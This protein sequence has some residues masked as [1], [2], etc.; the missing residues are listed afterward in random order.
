MRRLP[1]TITDIH[2]LLQDAQQLPLAMTHYPSRG[3]SMAQE[4]YQ[5]KQGKLFLK[6][7][8]ERNHQDCQVNPSSGTLAEREF[9]SCRLA[10][11][12][13]LEVPDLRLLDAMTTVQIW[14]DIPDAHSYSTLQGPIPYQEQMT[15]I[16]ECGVFDWITGQIDR[17]DANY[18]YDF[19]RKR[20]IL[21]DAAHAFLRFDG[22]IPDY[23][24]IFEVVSP[25][26]LQRRMTT[27][28][29]ESLKG[30]KKAALRRLVPLRETREQEALLRRCDQVR[31]I[32]TINELIQLYR[33]GS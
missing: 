7:V 11:H 1:K 13:G 14:Y 15:H 2:T 4:L 33:K 26:L 32:T 24:R 16:F 5:T 27:S 31:H 8:S 17:H 28:I 30:L 22:S 10:Q 25:A 21:I 23:L 3:Q 6:K 20:I 12:V 18:L 29:I 9:W 19:M